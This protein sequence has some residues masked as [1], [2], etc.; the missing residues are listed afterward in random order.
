LVIPRDERGA[1]GTRESPKGLPTARVQRIL[2]LAHG[3]GGNPE[4]ASHLRLRETGPKKG[5]PVQP[6]FLEASG[7]TMAE[8]PSPHGRREREGWIIS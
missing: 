8:G 6:T 1:A 7:V 5:D 4:T 3:D 2:P